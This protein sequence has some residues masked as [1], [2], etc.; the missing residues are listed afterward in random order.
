MLLL[1]L[2]LP[3]PRAP[4]PLPDLA[5]LGLSPLP[6]ASMWW[7]NSTRVPSTVDVLPLGAVPGRFNGFGPAKTSVGVFGAEKS[8]VGAV[9]AVTVVSMFA[10]VDDDAAAAA[11]RS[12]VGGGVGRW[13]KWWSQGCEGPA[14]CSIQSIM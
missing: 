9:A 5:D 10:A 1:P 12:G 4:C 14:A 3:G 8:V 2:L 13:I 7:L 6:R 11:S